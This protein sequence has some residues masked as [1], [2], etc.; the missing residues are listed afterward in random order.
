MVV[1]KARMS[2]EMCKNHIWTIINYFKRI[3]DPRTNLI[4]E[5][6]D[7]LDLFCWWF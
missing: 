5:Q 6:L 4:P 7:S 2:L 3:L 1:T